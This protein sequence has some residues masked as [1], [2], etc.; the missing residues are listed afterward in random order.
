[1]LQLP[2]KAEI[3]TTHWLELAGSA[4]EPSPSPVILIIVVAPLPSLSPAR[5]FIDDVLGVAPLP[6]PSP[7]KLFKAVKIKKK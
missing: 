5:Q 6:S 3:G 1:L 2:V 4:P 7:A